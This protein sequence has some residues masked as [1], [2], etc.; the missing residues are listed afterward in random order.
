MS[1]KMGEKNLFLSP[2][3]LRC[4]LWVY[5]EALP[6]VGNDIGLIV[7]VKGVSVEKN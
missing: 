2:T 5:S 3:F 7:H 6:L 1:G 4:I